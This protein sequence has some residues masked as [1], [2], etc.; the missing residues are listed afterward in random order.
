M[1]DKDLRSWRLLTKG[2]RK[3]NLYFL[4]APVGRAHHTLYFLCILTL[5]LFSHASFTT[6][7]SL[8]S[9]GSLKVDC[10][11]ASLSYICPNCGITLNY[12]F[13]HA[14]KE[15]E[16]TLF[17]SF[18]YAEVLSLLFFMKHLR[19]WGGFTYE[20][21]KYYIYPKYN[22]HWC[23]IFAEGNSEILFQSNKRIKEGMFILRAWAH[24]ERGLSLILSIVIPA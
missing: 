17:F 8:V 20:A 21:I 12:Y 23:G 18:L 24:T 19:V 1:K 6:I 13:L 14:I 3:S 4:P 16:L 11:N 10:N 9:I 7:R 2:F 5:T 22:R 15:K